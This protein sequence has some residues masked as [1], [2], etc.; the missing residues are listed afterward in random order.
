MEYANHA[1]IR[2]WVA[3][4]GVG[5]IHHDIWMCARVHGILIAPHIVCGIVDPD[6]LVLKHLVVDDM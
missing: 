4:V 1:R 3:V 2:E 6:D 5:G